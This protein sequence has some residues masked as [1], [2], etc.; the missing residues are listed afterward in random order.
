MSK[1]YET[2]NNDLYKTFNNMEM[3]SDV[4]DEVLHVTNLAQCIRLIC[5][6]TEQKDVS[7]SDCLLAASLL[8]AARISAGQEL[9]AIP[10]KRSE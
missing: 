1:L 2:F 10:D 8:T 4:K 6:A 5:K 7:Q 9:N 3:P